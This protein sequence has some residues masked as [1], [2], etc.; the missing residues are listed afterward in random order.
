[1]KLSRQLNSQWGKHAIIST[2]YKLGSTEV[3]FSHERV[4]N[5]T[6]NK[7]VHNTSEQHGSLRSIRL[8]KGGLVQKKQ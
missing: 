5:T 3:N 6:F 8:L 1:M 7:S 2:K 4:L